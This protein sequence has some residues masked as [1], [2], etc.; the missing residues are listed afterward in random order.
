MSC[1]RF[2]LLTAN[3]TGMSERFG[4]VS[5]SG[6]DPTSSHL[7]GREIATLHTPQTAEPSRSWDQDEGAQLWLVRLAAGTEE[8]LTDLGTEVSDFR[9]SPDGRLVAFLALSSD[10]GDD[11][12]SLTY[13]LR[14]SDPI[15]VETSGYKSDGLGF[16]R[17][18]TKQLFVLDSDNAR[19]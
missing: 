14:P 7:Q 6:D 10:R 19:E 5:L 9:W 8:R 17:G 3:W 16:R 2:A 18:F 1:T 13:L 15:V 12:S 4:G 11:S